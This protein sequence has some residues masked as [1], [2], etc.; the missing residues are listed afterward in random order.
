MMK[1]I[2]IV[3]FLGLTGL[4]SVAGCSKD[5]DKPAGPELGLRGE[6]CRARSDCSSGLACVNN[7]CVSGV[8]EVAPS[9]KECVLVE[10]KQAADCC[11]I[12]QDVCASL[13]QQCTNDPGGFACQQ[14]DA[15]CKCS[16]VACEKDKCVSKQTCDGMFNTCA[17]GLICSNGNC[18]QCTQE[19]DCAGGKSAC[20]DTK[21]VPKCDSDTDCPDFNRCDNGVCAKSGCKSDRECKAATKNAL[22]FC[23]EE[24]CTV[25]CQ[26]DLECGNP[27]NWNFTRCVGGSCLYVGCETDKEC[28]LYTNFVG[29]GNSEILCRE[30]AKLATVSVGIRKNWAGRTLP[31]PFFYARFLSMGSSG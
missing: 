7:V 21:C 19:S 13:Q 5:E 1:N 11:F 14:Y 17:G 22:A 10:C 4:F 27:N 12:E 28:Q 6:S 3:G 25:P 9:A 15:T 2:L 29:Q 23:K 16:N 24:K 18:V 31:V 20:I 8:Y 26:S 30:V